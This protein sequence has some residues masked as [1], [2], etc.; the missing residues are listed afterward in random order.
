MHRSV[1]ETRRSRATRPCWSASAGA[2]SVT[3]VTGPTLRGKR[4]APVA[5]QPGGYSRD[6]VLRF[7]L[8][9]RWLGL[10]LV[11]IVL[12]YT[13]V[14]L[15]QWQ[16]SR[17]SERKDGNSVIRTNLD[18]KPVPVQSLLSTHTE[19]TSAVEWRAVRV[20]GRYDAAHQ[21]AVLYRTKDGRPGVDVV[22][23]FRTENGT[24]ILVDRG[25]IP[26]E[27]NGNMTQRLPA[28][29]S[30][31]VTL[32]GRVRVD[33]DGGSS[34]VTPSQGSVRAISAP[35]IAKTLPYPA[36]DGFLQLTSESPESPH[37]PALAGNPDLGNGPSYFYG[38]QWLF[39]AALFFGFWIYFAYAEYQ[40]KVLGKPLGRRPAP[41]GGSAPPEPAEHADG[42]TART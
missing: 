7:L 26:S 16:F 37:A 19:P 33:S 15:S 38:W 34:E 27:A 30:G 4:P 1:S 41:P 39:F 31:P 28:P 21:L 25:W 13:C 36:Y 32:T 3:A 17:Y 22:T 8:K 29:A 14:R 23:P 35:A 5:F 12:G 9:P 18:A 40:E 24:A 42:S 11:V 10:L 2:S 6:V 20:T